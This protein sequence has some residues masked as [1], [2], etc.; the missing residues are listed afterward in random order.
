M[1]VSILQTDVTSCSL[2]RVIFW[3]SWLQRVRK[4]ENEG[5]GQETRKGG[6]QVLE[7]TGALKT[8]ND[9]FSML[10]AMIYKSPIPH[11]TVRDA[12]LMVSDG[13]PAF[14]VSIAFF[15]FSLYCE[16]LANSKL[17]TKDNV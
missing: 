5:G 17:M 14:L 11:I 9:G 7:K 15:Y 3:F 1:P 13:F 10:W 6:I 4:R 16:K 12:M 8:D 2:R